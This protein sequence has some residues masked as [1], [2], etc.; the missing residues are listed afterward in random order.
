MEMRRSSLITG[1][2]AAGLMFAA[3]GAMAYTARPIYFKGYGAGSS[4]NSSFSFDG[5][6]D[7]LLTALGNDNV[8]GQNLAQDVAEYYDSGDTCT[9]TDGTMGEL[10][11]L[12]ES[13]SVTTYVN[14]GQIYG[15][16]DKGTEC[17]SF[18]TGVFNG[19]GPFYIVDGSGK[20]AGASGTGPQRWGLSAMRDLFHR[21]R[22]G[23]SG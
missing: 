14:G 19:S 1:L 3:R 6:S 5:G 18:T 10:Y 7:G 16:A 13:I 22:S 17:V 2:V 9:A 21:G 15:F 12:Y 20:F 4:V 23:L 8:G 11:Y